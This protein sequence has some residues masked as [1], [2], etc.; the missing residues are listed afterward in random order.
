MATNSSERYLSSFPEEASIGMGKL[1]THQHYGGIQ[2]IKITHEVPERKL[3]KRER[4]LGK[5]GLGKFISEDEQGLDSSD[6][7]LRFEIDTPRF[8]LDMTQLGSDPDPALLG[9]VLPQVYGERIDQTEAAVRLQALIQWLA[10]DFTGELQEKY[11]A[12]HEIE[13][14]YRQ[15]ALEERR[16][17]DTR[18]REYAPK[19][20]TRELFLE[21]FKTAYR[22]L[23]LDHDKDQELSQTGLSDEKLTVS[24]ALSRMSS[25]E[26]FVMALADEFRQLHESTRERIASDKSIREAQGALKTIGATV[27]LHQELVD[28]VAARNKTLSDVRMQSLRICYLAMRYDQGQSVPVAGVASQTSPGERSTE[29]YAAIDTIQQTLHA[30]T[31]DGLS[32]LTHQLVAALQNVSGRYNNDVLNSEIATY[33]ASASRFATTTSRIDA[34]RQQLQE[35]FGD[36]ISI[37]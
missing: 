10:P 9:H 24:A 13:D 32:L 27:E 29:W 7:D 15:A 1:S 22:E 8:L 12:I 16:Q 28:M 21:E 31:H 36:Y 3:T 18:K 4:F 37:V 5:V 2:A 11:T 23:C 35:R 14:N 33:F 25:P 30:E 17:L 19:S 20:S 34:V 26:S 6:L